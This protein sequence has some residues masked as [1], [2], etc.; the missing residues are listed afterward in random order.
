[1]FYKKK[2]Q[3]SSEV[4]EAMSLRGLNI[5]SN[6]K[7]KHMWF[8]RSYM[9]KWC[10]FI[11][12]GFYKLSMWNFSEGISNGRRVPAAAEEDG[13]VRSGRNVGREGGA[14][15]PGSLSWSL[16][17]HLRGGISPGIYRWDRQPA[18]SSS[19]MVQL[20]GIFSQTVD[21]TTRRRSFHALETTKCGTTN[22]LYWFVLLSTTVVCLSF[23]WFHRMRKKYVIF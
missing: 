9:L 7:Y 11:T 2:S 23:V 18:E 17:L 15:G 22:I 1:M 19:L 20:S 5:T 12:C 21:V 14:A 13:G 6:Y 4:W 16:E 8:L 10:H 3:R